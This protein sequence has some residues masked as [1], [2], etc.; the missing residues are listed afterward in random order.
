MREFLPHPGTD[1]SDL[2]T[3]LAARLRDLRLQRGMTLDVLAAE[4]GISRGT[5]SR[6]ENGETSP[7]ADALGRLCAAWGLPMSRLM[8]MVEGA[9]APLIR[10]ADQEVWDD[11][12]TGFTRRAVSPPAEGFAGTVVESTL[13]P[14]AT[15]RY[16]RPPLRGMEH[17]L[18]MRAGTLTLT[19]G[20]ET[21]TLGPG[22]CLRY[23]LDGPSAF[24]AGPDGARYLIFLT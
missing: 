2:T 21:H 5:L 1:L 24:H 10:H 15:I 9:D 12:D 6:M 7:T 8:R 17:H 18:V 4:S 14:G 3:R 13:R 19:V 20:A 16:D 23:L 22:D 11:Q